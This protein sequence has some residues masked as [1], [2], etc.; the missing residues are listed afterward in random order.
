MIPIA[1]A[2]LNLRLII[3]LAGYLR[4]AINPRLEPLGVPLILDVAEQ[5]DEE[6]SK[7][8]LIR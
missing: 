8:E 2:V 4:L 3:Q 6:A 5:A 1:L 7:I